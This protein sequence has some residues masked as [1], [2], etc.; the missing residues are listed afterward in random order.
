MFKQMKEQLRDWA[1]GIVRTGVVSAVGDD[2]L[3]RVAFLDEDD[4]VTLA[5]PVLVQGAG[6]DM[7][8]DWAPSVDD[9]V[10][11]AFLP[12]AQSQGW[13]LGSYY[14]AKNKRRVTGVARRVLA[15]AEVALGDWDA[16]DDADNGVVRKADL[17]AAIDGVMAE[18]DEINSD[19]FDQ[20][21]AGAGTTTPFK[22]T[23][24]STT[25]PSAASSDRVFS[26]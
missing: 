7:N 6:D 23:K 8:A 20:N 9:S 1:G 17:Q 18:V 10:L 2:G 22:W 12:F 11:C 15:A 16:P 24:T 21:G 25:K 3:V 26:S 5:L 14:T 13:V 4:V 19:L